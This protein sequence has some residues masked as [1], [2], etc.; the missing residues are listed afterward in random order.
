M[1]APNPSMPMEI[2]SHLTLHGSWSWETKNIVTTCK[3]NGERNHIVYLHS[4]I[5]GCKGLHKG[6]YLQP[7][8][9][10]DRTCVL[11]L[12]IDHTITI[13]ETSINLYR[14]VQLCPTITVGG[15]GAF[16]L[17]G[18]FTCT[19][20]T[21]QT[22]QIFMWISMLCWHERFPGSGKEISYAFTELIWQTVSLKIQPSHQGQWNCALSCW[23]WRKIMITT[24]IFFLLLDFESWGGGKYLGANIDNYEITTRFLLT[25]TTMLES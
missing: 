21:L 14:T 15:R 4:S 10:Q 22:H 16:G 11:N 6:G 5:C 19:Q 7:L 17:V 13:N 18:F 1:K 20:E 9:I 24:A 25:L 2:S 8:H 12:K 23:Q 3:T